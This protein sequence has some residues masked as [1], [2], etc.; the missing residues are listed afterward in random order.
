LALY[1]TMYSPLQMAADIPENYNRF[2]DAFQFI[3]DVPL[4]WQKSVYLEAEPGKVVTIAR[5]DKHSE[6]WYVG[7]TVN[8]AGHQTR[9]S[10][11]FLTPGKKYEAVIYADGKNADWQLNPQSYTIKRQTVTSKSVLKLKSA[12]GGGFAI[13]L[14]LKGEK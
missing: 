7:S 2:L 6:N 8:G 10:L 11:G 5:K 9:L 13:E 1:I 4:D 3:K 12:P 14:K